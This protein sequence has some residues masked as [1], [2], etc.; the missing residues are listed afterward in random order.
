MKNICLLKN[1]E[2]D[3][4]DMKVTYI[5]DSNIVILLRDLFYKPQ[6]VKEE[7]RQEL[8]ELLSLLKDQHVIEGIG[9]AECSWDFQ[10]FSEDET[11]AQRIR[12]AL[13]FLL[14]HDEEHLKRIFKDLKETSCPKHNSTPKAK[15]VC[16]ALSDNAAINKMILPTI[17]VLLKF[18][19]LLGDDTQN[20]SKG[21]LPVEKRRNI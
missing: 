11:K 12:Y 18:Y 16:G 14:Q 20:I 13:K 9:V 10:E 7:D 2:H 15:R 21:L 6:K 1:S 8:E 17:A 5:L 19:Q 3:R 4:L